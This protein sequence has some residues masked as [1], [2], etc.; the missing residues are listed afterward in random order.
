MESVKSS[1]SSKSKKVLKKL[2]KGSKKLFTKGKKDKSDHS[3][4]SNQLG[5]SPYPVQPAVNRRFH[6][7]DSDSYNSDDDSDEGTVRSGVDSIFSYG[8]SAVSALE[9]M[10]GDLT[11]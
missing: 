10:Y 2:S 8:L 1:K 7:D 4:D 9:K 11:N 6:N 5:K 3:T